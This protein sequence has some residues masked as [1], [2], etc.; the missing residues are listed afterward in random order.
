MI[1]DRI[2]LHSVL[3]PLLIKRNIF[4]TS[5]C[6]KCLNNRFLSISRGNAK[7]ASFHLIVHNR[8][9]ISVAV[10]LDDGAEMGS[11]PIK[12]VSENSSSDAEDIDDEL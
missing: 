10:N 7:E 1:T 3:L 6:E 4:G 9:W 8:K 5:S 12:V 11:K 2:G